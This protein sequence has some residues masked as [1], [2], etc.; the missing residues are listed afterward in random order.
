M[1]HASGRPPSGQQIAITWIFKNCSRFWSVNIWPKSGQTKSQKN[2][3]R[4][5]FTLLVGQNLVNKSVK[6]RVSNIVHASGRSKSG[7][8]SRSNKSQTKT[9]TNGCQPVRNW[10][11]ITNLQNVCWQVNRSEICQKLLMLKLFWQVNRSEICQ[12]FQNF[13]F[14]R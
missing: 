14:V 12:H 8:K 3:F 2:D 10:S 11:T 7:Q 1:I 5:L 4:E 9:P 13:N 6:N